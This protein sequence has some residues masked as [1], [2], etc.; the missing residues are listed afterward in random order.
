MQPTSRIGLALAAGA[1]LPSLIS[2]GED[3]CQT[4]GHCHLPRW[5]PADAGAFTEYGQSVDIDGTTAAVSSMKGGPVAIFERSGASWVQVQSLPDPTGLDT[6]EYGRELSLD[7]DFLAVGSPRDA[8]LGSLAGAVHMFRRT[9]GVWELF[10]TVY[11]PAPGDQRRFGYHVSLSGPWLGASVYGN[12]P[13]AQAY[14][15]F[16]T[17]DEWV[18]EAWLGSFDAGPGGI[19]LV[20][21]VDE[22]DEFTCRFVIGEPNN[23]SIGNDSGAAYVVVLSPGSHAMQQMPK[24][25]LDAQDRF[26]FAVAFDGQRVAIGAHGDDEAG[27]NAG[28]VYVYDY[29]PAAFPNTSMTDKILP[30]GDSSGAY[31]GFA[32]DMD[33]NRI[34]VGAVEQKSEGLILGATYVYGLDF[35]GDWPMASKSVPTDLE[36]LDAFGSDVAIDSDGVLVGARYADGNGAGSGAAYFIS[37]TSQSQSGGACP[38]ESLA[39]VETYGPG[40]PGSAGVPELSI[41]RPLVPGE[42]SLV[43][44]SDSLVGAVPFFLWGL[45]PAEIPFDEGTLWMADP[46][47]VPMPVVSVLGQV[48]LQ[49]QVPD[50]PV[51]CG[52]DVVTQVMF[53]DP[54]AAGSFSTAQSNALGLMVGY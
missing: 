21:R 5:V 18:Y 10:D 47:I 42:D 45:V 22:A 13:S 26:G 15:F 38:C 7:G 8:T 25:P 11:D 12:T 19:P 17:F 44:L 33:D 50:E 20:A 54:G 43:K 30:C 37:L 52:L 36:F 3:P 49:I 1:L 46:H 39:G 6:D 23:D 28:A 27:A 24:P 16:G 29:I 35:F 31:F 53:I 14:A 9:G 32:L 41:N 40:K 34:A 2:A 4:S 48:G 51:L